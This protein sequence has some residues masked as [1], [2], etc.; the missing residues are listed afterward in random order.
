MGF[1]EL[2]KRWAPILNVFDENGVDVC[3]EI[4]PGEDLT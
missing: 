4:H 2:A 1:E 3:Y